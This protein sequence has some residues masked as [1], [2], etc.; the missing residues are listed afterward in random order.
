MTGR[1]GPDGVQLADGLFFH[2]QRVGDNV[3]ILGRETHKTS[4]N[5]V[6]CH[7]VPGTLDLRRQRA[8]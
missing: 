7:L 3:S 5:E 8:E 6:S 2:Q 4:L 1:F